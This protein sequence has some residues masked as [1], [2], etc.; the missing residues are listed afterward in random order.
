LAGVPEFFRGCATLL[1]HAG[2][3][4]L[5]ILNDFSLCLWITRAVRAGVSGMVEES[6]TESEGPE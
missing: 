1:P 2:R 4:S 5:C 3:A 6:L